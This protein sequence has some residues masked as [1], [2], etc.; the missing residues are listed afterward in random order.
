[1]K[2][3]I[4]GTS[5]QVGRAVFDLLR[6]EEPNFTLLTPQR[7]TL[8]LKDTDHIKL[9]VEQQRPDLIIN[10][11]AYTAVDLAEDDRDNA[12]R[13]NADAP[14]AF[15]AV[16]ARLDIP[17]IHFSTDYVFN[18]E[19][20]NPQG[21]LCAYEENDA[22]DPIGVYGASKRA[23]EVAITELAGRHLILR[24][25][26]VYSDFGK[27]FMLTMLRLAKEREQL[28]IVNDQ[29][30]A[31]TSALWI[32]KVTLEII[33]Q[34]IAAGNSREWWKEHGG[35]VHLTPSNWTNWHGFA[36]AIMEKAV[37]LKL[38]A[39][40]PQVN[41][42]PASAYPTRAKRP[43]NSMLSTQKLASRFGIRVPQWEEGLRECLA[44]LGEQQSL[45]AVNMPALANKGSTVSQSS[46][47]H[48]NPDF[49]L[50]GDERGSLIAVE[51][52][53]D[54]PFPIAR[55]YYIF[56][57]KEGVERGFH[58][59]KALKQVAVAVRGSCIMQLDNGKEKIDILMNDP[60]KSVYIAPMV[61]HE[62]REFSE[63]CVLLVFAD[64]A[65]DESDYIRNYDAFLAALEQH[66]VSL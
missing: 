38:L 18:G 19:K 37:T 12:F 14:R 13:I 41:G 11:A 54:V 56:A 36:S 25:S 31:P 8:D 55:V 5:G 4:T 40:A 15:A 49:R 60:A 63:D 48:H 64:Q 30:G 33:K 57:T 27:N 2:I 20:R 1:M 17:L 47:P 61:W 26:W 29:W 21:D 65:Y 9:Y 32:A 7:D 51:A 50:L 66:F 44:K 53:K 10:P 24:T 59:H 16:A 28:S 23:G 45:A 58:A 42:I 39:K 46:I 34:A 43:T 22:C 62:M 3:L 52:N 6:I 35:I